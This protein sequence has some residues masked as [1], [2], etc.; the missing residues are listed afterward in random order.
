[1]QKLIKTMAAFVPTSGAQ[2]L[3]AGSSL[4][5]KA[6]SPLRA[7]TFVATPNVQH[8]SAMARG[9][10]SGPLMSYGPRHRAYWRR[11]AFRPG[12]ISP[13][14]APSGSIS[15]FAPLV[16]EMLGS[17][18]FSAMENA[19][20][21]FVPH[22]QVTEN[23]KEYTLRLEIPGFPKES[24]KVDVKGKYLTIKGDVSTTSN[25]E[26]QGEATED[27]TEKEGAEEIQSSW[28]RTAFYSKFE[29]SFR[30]PNNA[31]IA[32][33]AAEVKDGILLISIPKKQPEEPE[34]IPINIQ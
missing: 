26:P 12:S 13:W 32:G 1:M 33:I 3:F 15:P 7:S 16:K 29:R 27:S 6:V 19:S 17:D 9:V 20:R 28:E 11:H 23:D 31:E 14:T 30:L 22:G 2:S 5:T 18:V 4:S 24:V 8:G 21:A 10:K 25:D 34:T